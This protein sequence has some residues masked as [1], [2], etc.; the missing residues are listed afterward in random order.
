MPGC[1]SV[2]AQVNGLGT[3]GE[4]PPRLDGSQPWVICTRGKLAVEKAAGKRSSSQT[5]CGSLPRGPTG[6]FS[7]F[8]SP[9]WRGPCKAG[10]LTGSTRTHLTPGLGM[11]KRQGCVQ[12]GYSYLWKKSW[13]EGECESIR[14]NQTWTAWTIDS[15][16]STSSALLCGAVEEEEL[17]GGLANFLSR[18]VSNAVST[19]PGRRRRRRYSA[20]KAWMPPHARRGSFVLAA[21]EEEVRERTANPGQHEDGQDDSSSTRPRISQLLAMLER[22][23]LARDLRYL[24]VLDQVWARWDARPASFTNRDVKTLALTLAKVKAGDGVS[25]ALLDWLDAQIASRVGTFDSRKIV[26]FVSAFDGEGRGNVA[27]WVAMRGGLAG[28]GLGGLLMHEILS[29]CVAFQ[30]VG[31]LTPELYAAMQFEL[32]YNKGP[33]SRTSPLGSSCQSL[34]GRLEL[35]LWRIQ[36]I[37]LKWILGPLRRGGWIWL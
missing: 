17:G 9:E 8:N 28:R 27:F 10:M 35:L 4:S 25:R 36:G 12:P 30:R 26:Y 1:A 34:S 11:C 22:L 29:S 19:S 14:G 23:V 15:C 20:M 2:F 3:S 18:N 13:K 16:W 31:E 6:A 7:L 24:L 33:M 37:W 32:V 21:A 5:R